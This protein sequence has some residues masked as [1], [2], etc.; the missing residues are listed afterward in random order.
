MPRKTMIAAINEALFEEMRR[1]PNVFLIG[2]DVRIGVFAGTRGLHKEFGD[3]RVIDTPISELAVAGAGVGAAATG[4]RPIVDLMF[5][6]FLY[7]A[8]DQ[9]AN[10][11]GAMRYMFGGQ[12]TLPIVYMVQNGSGSS[13]GHHHSQSVHTFFMNMPL[14]KV[15]MPSTPYDVKGLLKAAIRDDNPVVFLNHLSL[16]GQRSD[17][18]DA[19]Y[20]IPLGQADIKRAG[21]D[22]TICTAG[23][24]V[25]HSLKAAAMLEKEGIDAEVIDLRTL[26]PWDETA[27]LESVAKTGRFVAVD[28]SYPVCGA[29]SEWA[30]TVAE[31]A[32]HHLKAPVRRVSTKPV[33]IP[34]SPVL[35]KA[36]VPSPEEIAAAVRELFPV[37]T[38]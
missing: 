16:G 20:V 14:I 1:D 10:Q 22:V 23:M 35:E 25:H 34:F 11:A 5:G 18:P 32:F 29:A 19:D 4:L 37:A 26:K 15:V 13:A 24:M 33:P 8:F 30:A 38:T 36:V 27:V 3:K 28:E 2:E 31:K 21:K 9:I 7:L 12:T 6:T 17:V